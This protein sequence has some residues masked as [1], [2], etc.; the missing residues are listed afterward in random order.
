MRALVGAGQGG[1]GPPV[2][3]VLSLS[4]FTPARPIPSEIPQLLRNKMGEDSKCYSSQQYS[5]NLVQCV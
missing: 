1:K 3:Q 2:K 4:S 5:S